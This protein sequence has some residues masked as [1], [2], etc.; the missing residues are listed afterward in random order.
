[1]CVERKLLLIDIANK[2]IIIEKSCE[3]KKVGSCTR[4]VG[5]NGNA[6]YNVNSNMLQQ[7]RLIVN[8]KWIELH[9]RLQISSRHKSSGFTLI[10]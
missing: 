1:M 3:I 5:W 8:I 6:I 4:S 2:A 7:I 9:I 10:N